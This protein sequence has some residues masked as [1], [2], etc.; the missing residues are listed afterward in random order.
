MCQFASFILTK[1]KVFWGPT[2]SHEEIIKYHNLN[3][4]GVRGPNIVRIEILPP[5]MTQEGLSSPLEEWQYGVDQDRTPDWYSAKDGEARCRAELP[6]LLKERLISSGFREV[7]AGAFI[8]YGSSQVTAYGSSQVTAY[9]LSRVTAYG[10][11]QVMAHNSSQVTAYDLSR[12]MACKDYST[13]NAYNEQT[14]KP[15][16]L[17][18]VLVDRTGKKAVCILGK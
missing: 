5:A 14:V 1:E 3:Q 16:G 12:V 2:D 4:D 15:E 9:D 10:L 7:K 6:S 11:S 13:V 8:A 18:A 17:F